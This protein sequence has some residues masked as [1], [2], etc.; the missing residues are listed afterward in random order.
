MSVDHARDHSSHGKRRNAIVATL[1]ITYAL[2]YLGRVNLSVVLPAL[3]ADLNVSL[4][5]AG[6]LGTVYFWVYGISHF[7]SGQAGSQISPFRLVSF[8]LL[9][10][11]LVNIAFA[12]Q[13][14]LLVMLLLWGINGVAQSAGWAPMFRILAER[15]DRTQIKRISTIMPFSYVFGTALTWT[16]IGVVAGGGDWRVA[17]WLPGLLLLLVLAFW[18]RAGID[19]PKSQPSRIRPRVILAEARGI[20][21]ALLTAALAGFVF[22]GTIIWLP[23]YILDTGLI[24]GR[25][26]GFVAAAMQVMAIGGLFLARFR[27]VRSNQVFATAALMLAAA[28]G[29]L[30]LLTVT[31]GAL[32][33]LVVVLA[34]VMLNGA[35]G[36]T[37]SSMPLLLAPPGRAASVTGKINM[38]S[39]FWGGM[40]G[41]SIGALVDASGWSAVFG[42]WGAVL[43]L[44]AAI[45]WR[46]RAEE[47]R[48]AE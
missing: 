2:F 48:W 29:A 45:I 20:A 6:A 44:A 34:L 27:V 46:K 42:L 19:A 31:G 24:E 7:F 43:L 36:L 30:L 22:N 39:N 5:E 1:W 47:N 41:F 26:V 25:L 35:F 15:F 9:G 3:A 28:G 8:G 16:F 37:V 21:F 10:I 17:F 38:M 11:A 40:A 12:F 14:S 13:T 18:R 32:A 23:T 33:L 4:A